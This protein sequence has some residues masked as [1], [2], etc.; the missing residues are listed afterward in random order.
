VL[1]GLIFKRV[2]GLLRGAAALLVKVY[3]SLISPL[4]GPSCR[5][6]PTCSQYALEAFAGYTFLRA[7]VLIFKRVSRCHPFSA[8]GYDPIK[9]SN[10]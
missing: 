1:L 6:S 3:R 10:G 4:F 9:K 8:G 5:F 2:D 7:C